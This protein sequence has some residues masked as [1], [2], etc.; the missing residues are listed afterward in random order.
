MPYTTANVITQQLAS[1]TVNLNPFATNN[2]EGTLELNPPMDNWVDNTKAPDLLIVDPSLQILQQSDS[3]NVLAIGDWKAVP[4]TALTTKTTS[5]TWHSGDSGRWHYFTTATTTQTYGTLGQ[6]N[7]LGYY[8][9][10]NNT[11]DINNNYITDV[12]IL[13]YIRSQ[14]VLLKA[15]GLKV[16]TPITVTFD[17]VNVNE[18]IKSCDIIE[19]T[20]VSGTFNSGDIIGYTDNNVFYQVA[21]VAGVYQYPNLPTKIRL[22]VAGNFNSVYYNS[23]NLSNPTI[24]S[25]LYDTAGNI[26]S[27]PAS[28][29]AATAKIIDVHVTG[30]IPAVGGHFTDVLGSSVKYYRIAYTAFGNFVNKYAI[31]GDSRGYGSVLAKSNT[32]FTVATGGTYYMRYAT[33]AVATGYIKINGNYVVGSN[34][35]IA[36]TYGSDVSITLNAGTNYIEF[37]ESPTNINAY[38][39]FAFAISSNAWTGNYNYSKT[40]GTIVY[41]SASLKGDTTPLNAGTE[42][43][44]PGGGLYYIGATQLSLSNLAKSTDNYYNGC[45]INVTT[46]YVSKDVLSGA[47]VT[48]K[49]N[50]S[51]TIS[52]YTALGSTVIL[53]TPINISIGQNSLTGTDITSTYTIT[54]THANYSLGVQS[55]GLSKLSTDESG[56]FVAIFDI[57]PSTFKTGDRIVQIDNRTTPNDPGSATSVATATFTASGLSTRSQSLSFGASVAGAKNTFT[58]TNYKTNQLISS[59]TTYNVRSVWD[60][61]AQSFLVQKDNYPNGVFLDSIDVFFQSKPTT[62]NDPVTLSIVPTVNGYPGGETLD[63]SIVTLTAD[64]VNVSSTPHYLDPNAKTTFK[65]SAPVY[66]QPG[67]LYAFILKTTSDSYNIY[68]SAQNAIAL[69]SSVKVNYT[70]PTPTTITKIGGVPGIG[71]MFES[72]NGMTWTAEQNKTLMMNINR[73]VFDTASSPTIT[74]TV[75]A[76]LP[77]RKSSSGD[78]RYLQDPTNVSASSNQI[79]GNDVEAHA[80][81]I[82]TTDFIPTSTGIVYNYNATLKNG[83]IETGLATVTPGK[84]ACPTAEDIYLSDGRGERILLANSSNSFSINA[85][86]SSNDNTVSP[87][88]ADDGL[89]LFNTQWNINNLEL[90]NSQIVLIN[91]GTGYNT[92]TPNANVVIS[93]PDIVGGTQALAVANVVGG[94]VQSVYLTNPGSGYLSTPTI[95]I[96]GANTTPASASITSEFSPVGGNALCKYFTKKVVMAA[97]NDSQDLRVFYTAYKPIGTNIYVFYKVLNSNDTTKF[98]D[99]SWKLMTTIGQNK[100]VYSATRTDLYEFEAAPGTSG[101]ADNYLTYT[102]INGQTYDSFIQF[103]IKIVMTTKDK[104]TVPFISELRALALPSGTGI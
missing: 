65:F 7:T 40:T 16:N 93:S 10:I 31:W 12:S 9:N 3:V 69:P 21:T 95:T 15:S 87:V 64:K 4:G 14:E 38:G 51:S 67:V 52:S 102:N 81:N 35:A 59:T 96:T 42:V 27:H 8:Q 49:E 45:T 75:P 91:G 85:T 37:F 50:Y 33:S 26:V 24:Q 54:G 25:V 86:L 78:I 61:V 47:L 55:G 1:N 80:F 92:G 73:C 28:G 94:I 23:Q 57:P 48:R 58:Q 63:N 103:A 36:Q 30:Q 13:P 72:Q 68:H 53:S 32:S 99:N 74:F 76:G 77:Y 43:Q 2:T 88:L 84:Y 104:T 71:G 62:T 18:Y 83:N 19:L 29:T 90:S 97:G 22:Y 39:Y 89:T 17:G 46:T 56:N 66:I 100:N 34:S 60:P 79:A 101:I 70:D 98:D 11:Y 44:L 5:D 82:T 41:D 6:T 20:N